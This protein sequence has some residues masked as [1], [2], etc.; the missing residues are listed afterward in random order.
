MK[1][2]KVLLEKRSLIDFRSAKLQTL[3]FG[4]ILSILLESVVKIV[5]TLKSEDEIDDFLISLSKVKDLENLL[6]K[7]VEMQT[8]L[9]YYD[10]RLD[11]ISAVVEWYLDAT[12]YAINIRDS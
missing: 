3:V 7:S 9:S 1:Y 5:E 4:K 8:Y 2:S 6:H 10:I 11:Q 12:K